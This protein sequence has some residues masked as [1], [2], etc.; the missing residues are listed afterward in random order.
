MHTN[1][2]QILIFNLGSQPGVG[3]GIEDLLAY[4]VF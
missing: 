3:K 1:V 2:G 4:Y